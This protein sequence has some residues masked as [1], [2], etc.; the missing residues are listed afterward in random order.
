MN[1]ARNQKLCMITAITPANEHELRSTPSLLF[2]DRYKLLLFSNLLIWADSNRFLNK[3]VWLKVTGANTK[4]WK[5]FEITAI[6]QFDSWI[7]NVTS[8]NKFD[9]LQ[10]LRRKKPRVV[11]WLIVRVWS[12]TYVS[13]NCNSLKASLPVLNSVQVIGAFTNWYPNNMLTSWC[14]SL[15]EGNRRSTLLKHW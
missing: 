6:S 1:L 11:S 7:I 10:L 9:C 5:W 2:W 15:Y 4:C 13:A 3:V 12:T 14:P 8:S